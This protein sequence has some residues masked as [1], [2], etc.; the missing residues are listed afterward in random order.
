MPLA[1][2]TGLS[3]EYSRSSGPGTAATGGRR[4]LKIA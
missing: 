3:Q 2:L 1:D 4:V